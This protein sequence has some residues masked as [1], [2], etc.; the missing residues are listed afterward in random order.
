MLTKTKAYVGRPMSENMLAKKILGKLELY[1]N[2]VLNSPYMRLSFNLDHADLS[3]MIITHH[4]EHD[5]M[6]KITDTGSCRKEAGKS[7]DP[8]GK[9]RK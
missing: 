6:S 8:A 7:P 4:L 3:F 1:S 5:P 2:K 9:Q